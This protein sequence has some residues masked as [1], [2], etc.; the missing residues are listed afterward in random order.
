MLLEQLMKFFV[1]FVLFW[2]GLFGTA[3][4]LVAGEEGQEIPVDQP[5]G[6]YEK[7]ESKEEL[8][9]RELTLSLFDTVTVDI[10]LEKSIDNSLHEAF[11]FASLVNYSLNCSRAPPRSLC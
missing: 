1:L 3:L 8:K 4:I 11:I 9:K 5:F 7:N 2:G 10:L 6:K